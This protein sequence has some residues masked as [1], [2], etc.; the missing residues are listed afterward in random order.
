MRDYKVG[1]KFRVDGILYKV[2][3]MKDGIPLLEQQES[4]KFT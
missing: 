4:V 2:V 3:S 1:E